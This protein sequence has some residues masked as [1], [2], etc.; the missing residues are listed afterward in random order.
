M[1]YYPIL[2]HMLSPHPTQAQEILSIATQ[3]LEDLIDVLDEGYKQDPGVALI[4][5]AVE[6]RRFEVM[7]REEEV[8]SI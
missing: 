2:L 5:R 7:Q 4:R 8:G 1:V 6:D 3:A